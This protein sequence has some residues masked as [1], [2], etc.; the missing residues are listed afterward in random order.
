MYSGHIFSASFWR[1]YWVALRRSSR[2]QRDRKNAIRLTFAIILFFGYFGGLI[3]FFA[4]NGAAGPFL[5]G[6][7]LSAS[8]ILFGW[9]SNRRDEKEAER[10]DLANVD[11]ALRSRLAEDGFAIA[12]L[13]TRASSEA[14]LK[15]KELPPGV[16]VIT[17]RVQLDKLKS[18][19]KWETLPTEV[20]DLLLLPDGHW[21][22]EQIN[23]TYSRFE[24]LRCLRWTLHLDD[25]LT[26]LTSL[27]KMNYQTAQSI[28]EY[29]ESM[30][31]GARLRPTWDIRVE[32]NQANT[33][34][35]RCLAEAIGRGV[36]SAS[37]VEAQ[38]WASDVND[39]A[40]RPEVRDLLAGIH[41]IS[42]VDDAT[43][44]YLGSLSLL[45]CRCLHLLLDLQL[46]APDWEAWAS[47]CFPT[48]PSA[49]E[50]EETRESITL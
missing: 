50:D 41:T 22:Q 21:S 47:I 29:P 5:V 12:T 45:R 19:N 14:M 18:M 39:S 1:S 33:F 13:L 6:A 10:E 46:E 34:L 35:S 31:D 44:R 27:P 26:P 32:R 17:R 36:I 43:L 42:E 28:F 24:V 48:A 40:R 2:D 30:L 11:L 7:S 15:Q 8:I 3:G 9:L 16:Q 25:S 20:R 49:E 37:N 23:S 4:L 38:A